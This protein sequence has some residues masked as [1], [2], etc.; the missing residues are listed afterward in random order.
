MW[1]S[2]ARDLDAY[3]DKL[4]SEI[5]VR[6]QLMAGIG[7]NGHRYEG[8]GESNCYSF[9]LLIIFVV[10]SKIFRCNQLVSRSAKTYA[11]FM[12]KC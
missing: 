2:N 12:P 6:K 1:F 7:E 8:I 4:T 11:D 5:E 10:K 3:S 9:Y